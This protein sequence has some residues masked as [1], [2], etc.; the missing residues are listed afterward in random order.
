MNNY[1]DF[2]KEFVK[3][4]RTYKQVN[5]LPNKESF[6]VYMT[7]NDDNLLVAIIL[8]HYEHIIKKFTHINEIIIVDE[9][10]ENT[11]MLMISNLPIYIPIKYDKQKKILDIETEIDT[12]NKELDKTN[13]YLSDKEFMSKAPDFVKEKENNKFKFYTSKIEELTKELEYLRS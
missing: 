2:V 10:P 4:I 11:D 8:C 6:D 7:F 12:L 9:R 3:V 13:N 5:N 1:F